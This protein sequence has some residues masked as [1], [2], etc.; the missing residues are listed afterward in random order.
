MIEILQIYSIPLTIWFIG[1]LFYAGFMAS[2]EGVV[3]TKLLFITIAILLW[4]F[5][6]GIMVDGIR[7]G[8]WKKQ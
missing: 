7:R 1:W 8:E 6:L 4:A 2:T 5:L 3:S